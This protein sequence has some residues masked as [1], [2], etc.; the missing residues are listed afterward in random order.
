MLVYARIAGVEAPVAQ[1]L[2]Q[3]ARTALAGRP[4]LPHDRDAAAL[5]L[6]GADRDTLLARATR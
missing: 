5:G 4:D 2:L 3:L 1:A 6:S